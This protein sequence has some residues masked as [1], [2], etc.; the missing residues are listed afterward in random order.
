MKNN[1]T[2]EELRELREQLGLSLSKLSLLSGISKG[3][4]GNYET[5]ARG[6][7]SKARLKI[8]D[9]LREIA[10]DTPPPTA[11]LSPSPSPPASC[12]TCAA[13]SAIIATQARTIESQATTI[14]LLTGQK[15]EKTP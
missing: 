2:G 4:I 10:D 11:S 3:S 9:A 1:F 7:S 12:P 15:K 14:A 13:L 8:A 5:G 6:I